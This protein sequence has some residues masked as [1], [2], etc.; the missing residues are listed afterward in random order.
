MKYYEQKK[1]KI[2]MKNIVCWDLS[3]CSLVDAYVQKDS[4]R[5]RTAGYCVS[6]IHLCGNLKSRKMD[7]NDLGTCRIPQN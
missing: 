5:R 6:R 4:T 2:E 3:P 1:Q 7:A